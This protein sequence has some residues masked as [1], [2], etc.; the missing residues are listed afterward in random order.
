MKNQINELNYKL[1]G[2]D[3]LKEKPEINMNG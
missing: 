2:T 1:Y 3:P